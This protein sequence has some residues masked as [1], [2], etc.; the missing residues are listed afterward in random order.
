M[1]AMADCFLQYVE[2]CM[3]PGVASQVATVMPSHQTVMRGVKF[4]CN[5]RKGWIVSQLV[6]NGVGGEI[7]LGERDTEAGNRQ[8]NRQAD[9][10][11]GN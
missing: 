4:L 11:E 2:G 9:S 7:E 5:H 10:K 8:T 3:P 1:A 6:W